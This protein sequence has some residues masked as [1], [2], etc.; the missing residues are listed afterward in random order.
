MESDKLPIV[1][2]PTDIPRSSLKTY[3]QASQSLL[4]DRRQYDLLR[5]SD[6]FV[7]S[8]LSTKLLAAFYLLLDR[9]TSQKDIAI[10]TQI[11]A[12]K[13]FQSSI[14][15][16][17]LEDD[18]NFDRLTLKLERA[19]A[20]SHK[21]NIDL[22]T[23]NFHLIRV[24]FQFKSS[25]LQSQ[26]NY[27]DTEKLDLDLILEIIEKTEGLACKFAY[28][29]NLFKAQTIARM[30]KHWQT[31]L[32]GIIASPESNIID[33][34][35]L[36]AAEQ[37]QILTTW[38]DTKTDKNLNF[39]C[40]HQAVAAQAR[41]TPERIALVFDNQEFT[42]RELDERANLLAAYLQELG[43]KS[44]VLV[45][46]CV[47]RSPEMIVGILAILKAGGAYVPLD[48]TY[49]V[50]R[51]NY[52]VE[53]TKLSV[54]LTQSNLNL[55]LT[56]SQS[57]Q[58]VYLD[59][60]INSFA[61]SS[62]ELTSYL[63]PNNLAYVI[64]TSGSTGKPKGVQIEHRTAVN[65]LTAMIDGK[66][67]I[68]AE[69][70]LL[71]VTT[72][73][74][75]ISVAEIFLPLIVGAKLIIASRRVAADGRQLD[76][77]LSR[78]KVTIAQATPVTWQL[79]LAAGWQGSPQL[80]ILSGGEPLSKDLA[81]QLLPICDRLW[82][83]YG[84]TEATIWSSACEVTASDFISIGRPL[85]NVK[86]YILDRHLR[87]VPI[88][89]PGELHIGGDCLARGYLN[90]PELTAAK[91]IPDPF[92]KR[93]EARLYKTGDLARY[94]EDGT[95]DCLGRLDRQIKIRGFRIEVGEIE[96]VIKQHPNVTEAVVIDVNDSSGNKTLVAYVVVASQS[97]SPQE[98]RN[99]LKQQ[100]PAYMIPTAFVTL[101][102]L[103]QTL[104]GKIDRLA[105]PPVNLRDR[106][107][108][109]E[110]V[111]P[112]DRLEAK[113]VQIWEKILQVSPIG[114]KSNFI[115]LGGN[116][117]LAMNL[118]VA[119]ERTLN[120]TL[121]IETLST[122]NTIEQMATSLRSNRSV[123][124][125]P[126]FSSISPEQ[127]RLLLTIVAGR[128]GKRNRPNSLMVAV[129]D[130]SIKPPLF[131]CANAYDEIAS[132]A[133]YIDPERG[134][135]FLESGYYAIEGTSRQIKEL[136]AYHL[137]DILAVQPD[138]PYF[139][140]GYSFGGFLAWEICQQLKAIGKPAAMLFLL[141]TFGTQPS[142]RLYQH[143]DYTLRTNWNRL[144]RLLGITESPSVHSQ[145]KSRSHLDRSLAERRD[146][147]IIRPYELPVSLFVATK[148]SYHSFFSRK[149][150]LLLFPT[151]GWQPTIAPQLK[152]AKVPGDHFSLLQEPNV[153]VLATRLNNYLIRE[154]LK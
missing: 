98:L 108:D 120:K 86:Y 29:C 114:V 35:L 113:L 101:N 111:A 145:T 49:P 89:V 147:Y 139:F 31:L 53:D 11:F 68:A 21:S 38:N 48:P 18:L 65:L 99:F 148:A 138:P 9:Y 2:L 37:Q 51:L 75:D 87:P 104:N 141:D 143:L 77:V 7:C 134:L 71:S 61:Q 52:M 115:D 150:A 8:K 80:K 55:D 36:T 151:L 126:I 149:L 14:V 131:I 102:S 59:R 28:N 129:R 34:P 23:N 67:G 58:I 117:I 69:D 122:L 43:V 130:R 146:S 76:R 137:R 47:E 107:I 105:L 32:E 42:Y 125:L 118:I 123:N 142:Y 109:D 78:H 82:N 16:L 3:K 30:L 153:R 73:C 84:P 116:S 46:I 112:R 62:C 106:A 154:E 128:G 79:L 133:K 124:D 83:M 90:R 6:K 60:G 103:P 97:P 152:V 33:L 56:I 20:L 44:N 54:L 12:D 17:Q 64:Y 39:L 66:P 132:L 41:K 57:L 74:F 94:L 110:Y 70:T 1:E 88:G 19:I 121:S 26:T 4:L 96:A 15:R 50:E 127:A 85:N 45:G 100:L 119:V 27:F 140:C 63:A 81:E 95:V 135:Y 144:T 10:G 5:Y 136:A 24:F 40:L 91:F 25:D 22:V 13:D 92:D 72:I 93:T